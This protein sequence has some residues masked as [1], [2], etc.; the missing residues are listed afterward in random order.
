MPSRLVPT[1]RTRRMPDL[2]QR[3]EA[4]PRLKAAEHVLRLRG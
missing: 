3:L 2:N 4:D 1:G